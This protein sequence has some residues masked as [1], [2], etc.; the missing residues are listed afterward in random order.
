[1]LINTVATDGLFAAYDILKKPEFEG[2]VCGEFIDNY[3]KA[4][5]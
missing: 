5:T 4:Q 1:M 2:D 3:M